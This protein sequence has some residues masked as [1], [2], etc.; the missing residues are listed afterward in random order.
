M[1]EH[2]ITIP[3]YT[4][5]EEDLIITSLM[6]L[7]KEKIQLFLG[8]HGL[9]GAGT[10]AKQR[11]TLLEAISASEIRYAQIVAYLDQL[12]PWG[13][14][15][16]FL[17]D[18]PDS[19]ISAWRDAIWVRERLQRYELDDYLDTQV[20]LALPEQLTLSSIEHTRTRLRITAVERR[21]GELRE[22]SLDRKEE[23]EDSEVIYKAYIYKIVRGFTVFDWDL[24]ANQAF[25][26]ITQLPSG[27]HYEVAA[28]RF[29]Q[30]INNVIDMSMFTHVELRDV[31]SRLHG[32]EQAGTPEARSQGIG[33]R[34]LQGRTLTG[35]SA[36]GTGALLGEAVI[37]EA[38]ASIRAVGV[39]HVGN[40]YW[41]PSSNGQQNAN[42]LEDEVHVELVGG[43]KRVNFMTANCEEVI[44]YVLQ[45]IRILG[46]QAR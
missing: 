23:V 40:F 5:A 38:M 45:R 4:A 42:P 29:F 37:D 36:S 43:F 35:R 9:T 30:L 14:Q 33:Y 15:H 28:S 8:V 12:E 31:I 44:R 21:E 3:T 13:K 25:L 39:G 1:T 18:G 34:T 2:A 16:V 41:L 27:Q 11:G 32:L 46:R 26:Q 24:T 17:Y 7:K 19:D 6:S 20:P 10:K 22:P